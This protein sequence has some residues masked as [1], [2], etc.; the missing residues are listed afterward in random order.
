MAGRVTCASG[1]VTCMSGPVTCTS[2]RLSCSGEKRWRF[3]FAR[4]RVQPRR[5]GTTMRTRTTLL[6]ASLLLA[7]AAH[8]HNYNSGY[9]LTVLVGDE[10]RPEYFHNGTTYVE[11]I[12]GA[13]YALRITNP[14]PH[15]VAVALS[16]DGLNTIDARHT[17]ARD[18]AK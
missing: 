17:A 2:G 1:R 5:K 18:G 13:S 9:G 4:T 10:T 14:T 15:R 12:R 7:A 8:A 16:V 6:L 11:A 3:L